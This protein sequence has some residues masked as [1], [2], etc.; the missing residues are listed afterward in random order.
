MNNPSQLYIDI[1]ALLD[2]RLGCLMGLHEEF[3]LFV[4]KRKDYYT[5][6]IDCFTHPEMGELSRELFEETLS[7]QGPSVLDHSPMTCMVEW[8]RKWLEYFVV[9]EVNSPIKGGV[10]ITINTFPFELDS[11]ERIELIETLKVYWGPIFPMSVICVDPQKISLINDSH[12][13]YIFYYALDWLKANEQ[14][15]NGASAFNKTVYLPKINLV[16]ALTKEERTQLQQEGIDPFDL[17]SEAFK[18]KLKVEFLPI[19][20]Y[21]IDAP[22]NPSCTK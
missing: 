19:Q 13:T 12:S 5:R 6:E 2:T 1:Q 7:K 9:Q 20:L 18:M 10:N 14:V 21:C 3:A 4:T 22:E 11:E 8:V 17:I 16:R 15:I